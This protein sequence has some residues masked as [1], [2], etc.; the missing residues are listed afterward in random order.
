MQATCRVLSVGLLSLALTAPAAAAGAPI[1]TGQIS[2]RGAPA[3]A[4]ARLVVES[5]G[6]V[7]IE[8][9]I[10]PTAQTGELRVVADSGTFY[11]STTI[12]L[13]GADSQRVHTF[14][15]HGFPAGEYDVVGELIS[16]SGNR[17]VVVRGAL[18]VIEPPEPRVP[19]AIGDLRR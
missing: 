2:P 4:P 1:S 18:L 11:R 12:G 16:A 5:P 15:W 3:P 19:P 9:M 13:S 7:E 14:E 10:R 17:E 6:T 8:I